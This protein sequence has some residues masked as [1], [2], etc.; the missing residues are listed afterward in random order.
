MQLKWVT[1][2]LNTT[3]KPVQNI[4]FFQAITKLQTCIWHCCWTLIETEQSKQKKGDVSGWEQ[5]LSERLISPKRTLFTSVRI[6]RV[7]MSR[8]A[9][10]TPSPRPLRTL[11]CMSLYRCAAGLSGQLC[12]PQQGP[13]QHKDWGLPIRNSSLNDPKTRVLLDPA[14]LECILKCIIMSESYNVMILGWIITQ[15]SKG[16]VAPCCLPFLLL[17]LLWIFCQCVRS[18]IAHLP[19]F[20]AG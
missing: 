13:A 18:Q 7:P 4:G 14:F 17:G 2:D 15:I 10:V 19:S 3:W 16:N 11:C 1:L 20:K 8:G 12:P 5:L 9:S 6:C